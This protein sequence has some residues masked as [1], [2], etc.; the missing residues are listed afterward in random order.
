MGFTVLIVDDE[1][2]P[3][4]V[5]QK[6]L[7]WSE[8]SVT[9]VVQA[10]DGEEGMEQ[11]KRYR[12]DIVISDIKMPRRNGI[13]MAAAIREFLPQC[14]FVFL[15]GY[16]D[17]EYLK[18]AIKVKAASYVEKPIDLEEI[19]EVLREIVEE[20]KQAAPQDPAERF[21]LGETATSR[22]LNNQ[23]FSCGKHALKQLEES[24][25][26]NKQAETLAG[27]QQMYEQI[28]RCEGTSPEYLRHLYCQVIFLFLNAAQA[29]NIQEITDKTDFL[30][31]TVGKQETLAGLWNILSKTAR[32]YF[33]ALDAPDPDISSRVDRYLEQ[34]YQDCGLTVQTIAD[35]LSFTNTYLCAAYKKACGKTINQRMTDIRMHHAKDL[36]LQTTQKLYE[37]AHNVGYSDGKYFAKLFTKETGLTPKQ[38]RERHLDEA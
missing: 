29:R 35:N 8:L 7:P 15:S 32:C 24:I 20:R 6:H 36:L 19:T 30:L 21:F 9:Q 22:T 33:S 34:H 27:L 25:K 28:V 18:G 26:H 16:T 13:E 14:Q 37:V 23:V 10:S 17:K 3:R 4:T 2:M 12:P 31:F 5:L 11:A 38:Y 1:T